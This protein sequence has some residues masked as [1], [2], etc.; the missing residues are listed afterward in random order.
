M[1]PERALAAGST[2]IRGPPTPILLHLF[3]TAALC[4]ENRLLLGHL[5]GSQEL[6]CWNEEFGRGI[7]LEA[8]FD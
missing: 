1:N 2:Y 6:M 8:L 7:Q 4:A 5:Y 3:H